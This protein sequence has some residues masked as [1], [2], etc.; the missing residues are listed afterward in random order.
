[1]ALFSPPMR[2][3]AG[4]VILLLLTLAGAAS[5]HNGEPAP[6]PPVPPR[7][8]VDLH[9]VKA[10]RWSWLHWWEAN[11]ERYLT[12]PSQEGLQAPSTQ[13]LDALR[14]AAAKELMTTAIATARDSLAI[15]SQDALRARAARADCAGIQ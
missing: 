10:P 15:E 13:P 11:R 3:S 12:S 9:T 8:A 4:S 7:K 2:S 1:M 14:E 5:A 6:F